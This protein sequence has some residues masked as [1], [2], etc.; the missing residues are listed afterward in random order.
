MLV[1]FETLSCHSLNLKQSTYSSLTSPHILQVTSRQQ[2]ET[3]F[4][5]LHKKE[6]TLLKSLHDYSQH[7]ICKHHPSLQG[8]LREN[9]MM[10]DPLWGQHCMTEVQTDT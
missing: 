1:F 6:K 7:S 10:K 5:R 9:V 4:E 2:L 8:F 3:D